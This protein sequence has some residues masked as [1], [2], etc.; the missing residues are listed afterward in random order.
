MVLWSLGESQQA[1]EVVSDTFTR[2][3]RTLGEDQTTTLFSALVL[4][5]VLWSLGEHQ[6]A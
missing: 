6:P 4:G 5:A 3:R 1:R 2:S